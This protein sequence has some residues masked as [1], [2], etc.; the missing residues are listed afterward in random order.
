MSYIHE[1]FF[2]MLDGSK[3]PYFKLRTDESGAIIIQNPYF[4]FDFKGYEVCKEKYK[5]QSCSQ[6]FISDFI[7]SCERNSGLKENEIL[8]RSSGYWSIRSGRDLYIGLGA[9]A[10]QLTLLKIHSGTLVFCLD[11]NDFCIFIKRNIENDFLTLVEIDIYASTLFRPW[12]EILEP[13]RKALSEI[14]EAQ[15]TKRILIEPNIASKSFHYYGQEGL[16][17]PYAISPTEQGWIGP[18]MIR[19]HFGSFG[20]DYLFTRARGG[21]LKKDFFKPSECFFFSGNQ[22]RFDDVIVIRG[23]IGLPLKYENVKA[24]LTKEFLQYRNLVEFFPE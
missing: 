6:N 23:M 9:E 7:E 19:N 3:S 13:F 21:W 10:L 8:W 15:I 2:M 14:A 16:V 24:V 20:V 11:N 22:H 17:F 18:S 5:I 12:V 4:G 1:P